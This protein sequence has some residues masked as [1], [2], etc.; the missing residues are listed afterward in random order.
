MTLRMIATKKIVVLVILLLLAELSVPA[1]HAQSTPAWAFDGAYVQY[2]ITEY[3]NNS[4]SN[5][6]ILYT[7]SAVDL[8]LQSFNVTMQSVPYSGTIITEKATFTDPAPFPA[9]NITVLT[10]LNA[11]R[12][13]PGYNATTMA[14]K[15]VTI[16]TGVG[17]F[18]A[19][20]VNYTT[21]N[22][23]VNFITETPAD[24]NN[25]NFPTV[26]NMTIWVASSSGLIIKIMY[27][28]IS[29]MTLEKTNIGVSSNSLLT[30]IIVIAI[31]IFLV[32]FFI[33]RGRTH[34]N[35]YKQI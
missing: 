25:P 5:S 2:G 14:I 34:S 16:K 11:G 29:S 1:A 31:L 20:E 27:G 9:E 19:D 3:A 21:L 22:L 35:I 32:V 6:T 8:A 10:A 13:L 33:I 30:L 26:S 23:P 4:T 15:H 24:L 28:N 12:I 17:S 7:L 18:A